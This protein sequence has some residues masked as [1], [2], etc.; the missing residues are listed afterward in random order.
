MATTTATTKNMTSSRAILAPAIVTEWLPKRFSLVRCSP[1][2][3]KA[4]G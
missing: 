1:W 4:T 2:A 3:W